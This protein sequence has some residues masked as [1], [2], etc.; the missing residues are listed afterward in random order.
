MLT[1][2]HQWPPEEERG[3]RREGG[4]EGMEGQEEG[5]ARGGTERGGKGGITESQGK[6]RRGRQGRRK[7]GVH[8]H[9]PFPI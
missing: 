7:W 3:K 8:T 2:L 5:R 9:L 6:E 1:W 4:R